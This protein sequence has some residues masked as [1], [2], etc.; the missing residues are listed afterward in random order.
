M[1]IFVFAYKCIKQLWKDKLKTRELREGKSMGRFS[2]LNFFLLH[3][4]ISVL[5]S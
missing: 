2:S 1:N 4:K 3:V 5:S